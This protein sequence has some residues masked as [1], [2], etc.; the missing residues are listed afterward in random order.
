MFLLNVIELLP[1]YTV[2]YSRLYH[3]S[4][5][6]NQNLILEEIKSQ[7]RRVMLPFGTESFVFSF[8]V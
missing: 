5:V 7:L 8:T 1:D 2:S 3:S 4:T 6:T